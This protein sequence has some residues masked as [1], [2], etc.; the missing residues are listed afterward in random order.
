MSEENPTGEQIYR[1]SALIWAAL[2]AA[3]FIFAALPYVVR[4]ELR[5]FDLSQPFLPEENRAF[6]LIFALLALFLPFVSLFLKRMFTRRA[7]EKQ[8]PLL[9]QTAVIAGTALCETVTALGLVLALAFS[10]QYFFFW[11]TVGIA[12]TLLHYPSRNAVHAASYH[13]SR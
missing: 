13:A 12:A 9:I 8:N 2:F 5:R 3:Q 6:V 11:P 4:P 10:Y 1:I 7:L